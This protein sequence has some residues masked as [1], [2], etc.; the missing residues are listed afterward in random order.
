MKI[1][2][3]RKTTDEYGNEWVR[4]LDLFDFGVE[5]GSPFF[6]KWFMFISNECEL[7]NYYNNNTS[8]AYGNPDYSNLQGFCRGYL[9][10]LN[11]YTEDIDSVRYVKNSHNKTVMKFDIPKLSEAEKQN[12][13][14]LKEL[15]YYLVH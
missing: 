10:A 12:L 5:E 9:A 2:Y 14:L 6:N 3:F 7:L 15:E 8:T 13:N 1:P 4:S 11:C